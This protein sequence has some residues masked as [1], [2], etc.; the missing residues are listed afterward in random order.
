MPQRKN[1]CP[2]H[3]KFRSDKFASFSP[4]VSSS[5][6]VSTSSWCMRL[7]YLQGSCSARVSLRKLLSHFIT[8]VQT[9]NCTPQTATLHVHLRNCQNARWGSRLLFRWGSGLVVGSHCKYLS[10]SL[11]QRPF[12]NGFEGRGEVYDNFGFFA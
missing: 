11:H 2:D 1:N 12:F 3:G 5:P 9:E 10:S 4:S 8:S 7:D 6:S